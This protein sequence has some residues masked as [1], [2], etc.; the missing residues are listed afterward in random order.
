ML[1]MRG[2][3]QNV[4]SAEAR[5][6]ALHNRPDLIEAALAQIVAADQKVD[7]SRIAPHHSRAIA[8]VDLEEE[9][10]LDRAGA[11][12]IHLSLLT[13]G[14]SPTQAVRRQLRF[15]PRTALELIRVAAN[16]MAEVA[17]RP[18]IARKCVV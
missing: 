17:A 1:P 2:W 3:M 9:L 7:Q 11:K 5:S 8:G 16:A 12:T 14:I 10:P 15:Q 4:S 13:A 6:A 18:D